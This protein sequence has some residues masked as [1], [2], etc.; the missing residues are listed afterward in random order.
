MRIIITTS[1]IPPRG[2]SVIE[3]FKSIKLNTIKPDAIYLNL[4]K[5][6]PRFPEQTYHPELVS[7][8][9]ELGVIINECED[10]GT[11][12][13]SIPTL[14]MENDPDTLFIVINDD[15]IYGKFFIEGLL[16]GYEE[17]KCVVGYSGIAYPDV[18][19]IYMGHVG[20]ILFQNHGSN[21]H[22]LESSFGIAFK[23]DWI[24]YLL[25]KPYPHG[26]GIYDD[27]VYGLL[28]DFIGISKR[29]VNLEY[30]GRNGDNWESIVK[31]IN[32]DEN[33]ISSGTTSIEKLYSGR[34]ETLRYIS[35]LFN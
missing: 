5:Y 14:K 8:C 11:L 2:L 18:A 3:T 7:K 30:I 31:F 17:F 21:T 32:Q 33:A 23:R 24:K 25:N 29:V 9:I 27:Y 1:T 6:V 22:I 20:Y 10:M 34:E 16:K 19:K 35:S 28:F 13:M 4:P 15:G 26:K 12:T